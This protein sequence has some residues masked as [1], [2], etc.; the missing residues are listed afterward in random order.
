MEKLLRCPASAERVE[1]LPPPARVSDDMATG[2][3]RE[4]PHH[5][6]CFFGATPLDVWESLGS[7]EG[8]LSR[9]EC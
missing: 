6:P 8:D 3:D 2:A 9:P 1:L 4:P 7:S 5:D